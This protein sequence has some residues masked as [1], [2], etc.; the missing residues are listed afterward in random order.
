MSHNKQAKQTN[1]Q[2]SLIILKI[3][4]KVHKTTKVNGTVI[5]PKV[6]QYKCVSKTNTNE[7]MVDY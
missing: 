3:T 1:F 5:P 4:T 7:L 6:G 2:N